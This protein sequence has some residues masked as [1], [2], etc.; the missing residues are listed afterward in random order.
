MCTYFLW[1]IISKNTKILQ[2]VILTSKGS[3]CLTYLIIEQNVSEKFE[4]A[5][6]MFFLIY[7]RLHSCL[8][9]VHVGHLQTRIG[10]HQFTHSKVSALENILAENSYPSKA[11]LRTLSEQL[12][13]SELRLYRWFNNRRHK[14]RNGRHVETLSIGENNYECTWALYRSFS[15]EL[16]TRWSIREIQAD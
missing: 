6:K 7:H 12:G 4:G 14:I 2:R 8:N 3:G 11:T 13:L 15:I 9:C 1:I 10:R 5:K 16:N